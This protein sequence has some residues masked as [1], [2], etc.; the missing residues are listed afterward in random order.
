[1][2]KTTEEKTKQPKELEW[3]RATIEP[4]V[5]L[6]AAAAED[7][8][9]DLTADLTFYTGASVQRVDY[10]SGDKYTLAF[11]MEPGACNLARLNSGAPMLNNHNSYDLSD[12]V[13][14]VESG[15]I[16]NGIGK[17]SVRF[18]NRPELAGIRADVKNK[19]IR[20]VSMGAKINKL[21]D[22]TPE[23][24]KQKSYLATDWEPMEISIV[25]IPADAGAGFLSHQNVEPTIERAETALKETNMDEKEV[26]RLAAVEVAR[27]DAIRVEALKVEAAT[28]AVTAERA[29]VSTIELACKPFT[30][31]SAEFR[32]ELISSGSTVEAAGVKILNQLAELSQKD[33][34]Q[35]NV[36]ITRDQ[37]DTVRLQAENALLHRFQPDTFKLEAGREFHGMT[38]LE[39]AKD[40]IGRNGKS[41]RG[42]SKHTVVELAF[43]GTTDFTNILANVANKTLRMGYNAEPQTFGVIA[44]RGTIV[45]FKPVNRTQIGDVN[46]LKQIGPQGEFTYTKVTDAKETYSLA[47][48]GTIFAVNRQT[49]I[50][51]DL[52]AFTRIPESLG[53]A[54]RRMESDTV[55]AVVTANANM[56]DGNALFS[57]THGN[58]I[59]TGAGTLI[60]VAALGTARQKMRVQTGLNGVGYLNLTPKYLVVP[61]ALETVAQ[62]FTVQTNIIVT[63]QSNINPV[64]P[65]LT[66]VPEPRLDANST[67]NWYLF[68]DPGMIDTIEYSY[69]EGQEGVYLETRMGF[70]VDGMELKAREDFA[71]KALDW[72]GMVKNT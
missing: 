68:S 14:V 4:V 20:N 45:D 13:G 48:F 59:G 51:D 67:A 15:S 25:P 16:E 72:R 7:D 71:A 61:T 18:S 27:L 30:A 60:S 5:R 23:N 63:Q 47:T 70:D 10:W 31:L 42:M 64:G 33:L 46:T 26:A 17:A 11:S 69:L 8:D 34:T 53:R 36:G 54:A 6:A 43:Q 2:E 1:L 29:R 22:V 21:K 55:W 50:N 3:L 24:S 12:V 9:E 19:I 66:V 39:M 62:Q 56:G 44:K 38:L 40:V 65:T 57:T 35:G 32:A 41:T 58:L 52:G 28:A 37:A 49:L